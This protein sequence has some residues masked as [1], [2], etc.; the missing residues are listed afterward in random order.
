MAIKLAIFSRK[1]K[2]AAIGIHTGVKAFTGSKNCHFPG[3]IINTGSNLGRFSGIGTDAGSNFGCFPGIE[4][5]THLFK[6]LLIK[7]LS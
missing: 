4:G 7:Q 1:A 3:I 5:N 6:I 2:Q